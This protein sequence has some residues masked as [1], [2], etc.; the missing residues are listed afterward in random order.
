LPNRPTSGFINLTTKGAPMTQGYTLELGWSRSAQY[1]QARAWAEAAPGAS[2]T[3]EGHDLIIQVPLRDWPP[4][5]LLQLLHWAKDW[6]GTQLRLDGT[7]LPHLALWHLAATAECAADGLLGGAGPLHCWGVVEGR[8][9]RVPCRFLD[10]ILP[11]RR[12]DTP[13]AIWAAAL[14]AAAR[15]RTVAACP[16]YDPAAIAAALTGWGEGRDPIA[17]L[18]PQAWQRWLEARTA[19]RL[20]TDVDLGPSD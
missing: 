14:H 15:T 4:A 2:V 3:G 16:F 9:H 17:A 1:A 6:K 5:R 8:T 10:A 18:I 20:L 13:V 7:P 19:K 12:D 11:Y